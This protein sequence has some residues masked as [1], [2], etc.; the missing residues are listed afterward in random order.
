MKSYTSGRIF[1]NG[2]QEL[3]GWE[4]NGLMLFRHTTQEGVFF[5]FNF[6]F[7]FVC[8]G[9]GGKEAKVFLEIDLDLPTPDIDVFDVCTP[10]NYV[11]TNPVPPPPPT[12]TPALPV[13]VAAA[14]AEER[15][16][17]ERARMETSDL[18]SLSLSVTK[19]PTTPHVPLFFLFSWGR[20]G[21]KQ[22]WQP[23]RFLFF[24]F[25]LIEARTLRGSPPRL[26]FFFFFEWG[27]GEI[28]DSTKSRPKKNPKLRLWCFAG[29][30]N[31]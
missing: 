9:K 16:G 28:W 19:P 6:L 14:A 26:P 18:F 12:H 29:Y 3:G 17:G 24:L 8:G 5:P 10:S 1:E 2:D 20:G 7:C 13:A 11:Q 31:L 27:D 21:R 22:Q 25:L 23:L 30:M 15:K 4:T